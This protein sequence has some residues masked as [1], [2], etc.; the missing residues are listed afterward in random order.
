MGTEVGGMLT[1]NL[2][3]NL[4]LDVGVANA[5]MGGFLANRTQATGLVRDIYEVFTRFQSAL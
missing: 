3:K 4:N 1:Y 2:A 5:F